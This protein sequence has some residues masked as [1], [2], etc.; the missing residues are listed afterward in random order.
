[1]RRDDDPGY[2][3]YVTFDHA[4]SCPMYAVPTDLFRSFSTEAEAVIAWTPHATCPA[5]QDQGLCDAL[6]RIAG[7]NDLSGVPD[8]EVEAAA[9]NAL[10]ECELIARAALSALPQQVATDE[11]DEL[12]EPARKRI[13]EVDLTLSPPSFGF[14]IVALDD[15]PTAQ[16]PAAETRL[17][18]EALLEKRVPKGMDQW[19]RDL[20]R[21]AFE[22]AT[23]TQPEPAA[24]TRL[25]DKSEGVEDA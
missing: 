22:L 16:P 4:D 3:W 12:S 6:E 23:L 15:T 20:A 18:L 17:A 5:V 11:G 2:P 9:R 7:K 25:R 19:V 21:E 14:G 24:E 1:M 13:A 10:Y 8:D